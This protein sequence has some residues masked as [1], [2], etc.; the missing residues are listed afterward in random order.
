MFNYLFMYMSYDNYRY[1]FLLG[2]PYQ[3]MVKE[4]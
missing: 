4:K 2:A 1:Y 3:A